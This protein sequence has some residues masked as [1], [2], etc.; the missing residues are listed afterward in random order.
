MLKTELVPSQEVTAN[1]YFPSSDNIIGG[2]SEKLSICL[3]SLN[4]SVP[5]GSV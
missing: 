4:S 3:F 5:C 1:N 2:L